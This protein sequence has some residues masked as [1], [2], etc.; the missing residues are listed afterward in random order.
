MAKILMRSGWGWYWTF[1]DQ[2]LIRDAWFSDPELIG[3][4]RFYRLF[5]G[6]IYSSVSV[7]LHV[8]TSCFAHI[9][10]SIDKKNISSQFR[11]FTH[12]HVFLNGHFPH[13]FKFSWWFFYPHCCLCYFQ[14][15]LIP[16]R[17]ACGIVW[18]WRRLSCAEPPIFQWINSQATENY[19]VIRTKKGPWH[20]MSG[21]FLY[22]MT[23]IDQAL[24][25]ASS[26]VRSA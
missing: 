23:E 6:D 3:P 25:G 11:W 21:P 7:F 17:L 12:A 14:T 5:R 18:G 1:S 13:L 15:A 9:N 24:V 2:Q 10:W 22:F 26:A 4:C 20:F 8:V 19:Y 16:E